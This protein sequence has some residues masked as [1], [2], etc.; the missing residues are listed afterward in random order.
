M[1]RAEARMEKAEVRV[2][3]AEAR[4]E[5][6]EARAIAMEKR[7]DRRLNGIAKLLEQGMRMLAKTDTKLAELAEAQKKTD[8]TLKAFM[9][10]L[11]HGRNGR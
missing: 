6:A 8:Q 4:V 9:N 5:K 3:K 11:R 2:E 10:S 7:F 1:E